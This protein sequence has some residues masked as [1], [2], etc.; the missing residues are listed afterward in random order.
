MT[1]FGVVGTGHWADVCHAAGIAAHPGA[2]LVAAWGRD[3]DKTRALAGR[4]GIDAET[5]LDVLL[6]KVDAVAFAVPPDVQAELAVQAAR[7]GCHLLLEKPLALTAEA[8]ERVVDEAESA[9]VATV[10][11]FTQ[12]FREPVD[13]WLRSVSD[14]DWDGGSGWFLTGSLAPDSPF[15]T[16]WRHEYGGLWDLGPHLLSLLIPA[17]GPVEEAAALHGRGDLT[18]VVLRH[19]EGRTSKITVSGTAPQ[20]AERLQVELWGA[21]G[22]SAAPLTLVDIQSSYSRALSALLASIETGIPQECSARFGAEVV[23]VLEAAE[24]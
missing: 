10:V 3:E 19:Q 12:R 16:P 4:Y 14:S 15:S 7:A 13:T 23:R 9:G 18:Q 6:E 24:A 21:D 20:A 2:E 8:A 22:F 1:R 11:F 5:D 17:L